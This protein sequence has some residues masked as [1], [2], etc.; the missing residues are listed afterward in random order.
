MGGNKKTDYQIQIA[1]AVIDI[2]VHDRGGKF[3]DK[4]SLNEIPVDPSTPAGQQGRQ[5]IIDKI[6]Q[7]FKDMKREITKNGGITAHRRRTNN[8]HTNLHQ[9]SRDD[10]DGDKNEYERC[11][12]E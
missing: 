12:Y 9:P 3:R 1:N 10:G 8:N 11:C 4:T 6:H 5:L 7:R 2:I